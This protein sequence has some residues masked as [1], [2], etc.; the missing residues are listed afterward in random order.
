MQ[1]MAASKVEQAGDSTSLALL[2]RV[3]LIAYGVVHLLIGWLAMQIAW[4]PDG[5][6]ADSSGALHTLAEQPFGKLLLCCVAVGLV[7]LALWQASEAIWGYHHLDAAKRRRKQVTS[8]AQ[9]IV[10]AV[11]GFSA[12]SIALGSGSSSSKTQQDA[13]TGVMAWPGGQVIVVVIG[14][15]VLGVGATLV[16][17]GVRRSFV[18][19]ID[20]SRMSTTARQSVLGL[21]QAGYIA[22]G[23][24]MGVVG[25]LLGY[26]AVTFDKREA[27]GLDAALQTILVQPFGRFLLTAVAL[28]FVAFGFFAII[29]S[30]YRRM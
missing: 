24:A 28:G 13:T 7:A 9:T 20:T 29:Q 25:A 30:R 21:G 22:K 10:Y 6:S 14:L 3:G 1:T 16:I 19:E 12:A 4:G 2:A 18:E 11:L 23:T 5:K 17:K 8:W 27:H 15:I 26:A